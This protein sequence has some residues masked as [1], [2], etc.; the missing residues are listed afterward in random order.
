M[1]KKDFIL[2]LGRPLTN[3]I[4]LYLLDTNNIIVQQFHTGDDFEFNKGHMITENL[5]SL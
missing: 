3:K 2:E 5:F 1:K 4:D